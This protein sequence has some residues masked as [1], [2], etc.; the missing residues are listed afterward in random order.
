ML[1]LTARN[2]DAAIFTPTPLF[3]TPT[4]RSV[5]KVIMNSEMRRLFLKK[6]ANLSVSFWFLKKLWFDVAEL[7]R[8]GFH[9]DYLE[10]AHNAASS[11][12]RE[13]RRL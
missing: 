3:I 6:T 10:P 7:Q 5:N 13:E 11:D 9:G 2:Q 1:T 8:E 4:R 12:G